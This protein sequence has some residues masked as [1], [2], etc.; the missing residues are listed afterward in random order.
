MSD[1]IGRKPIPEAYLKPP[2]KGKSP[3]PGCTSSCVHERQYTPDEDRFLK[4]MH[5]YQRANNRKFPTF[6]EVLDVLR[7]LG[8]REPVGG[9]QG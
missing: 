5:H 8:W 2:N 6:I 1:G 7:R 9:G 3:L 4:A